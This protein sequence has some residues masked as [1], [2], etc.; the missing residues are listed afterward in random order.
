M[1][2]LTR[3]KLLAAAGA[4]IPLV[5]SAVAQ[6]TGA[7]PSASRESDSKSAKELLANQA[8]LL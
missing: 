3:R 7:P 6:D 5:A 8:D 1:K 4:A 2:Q